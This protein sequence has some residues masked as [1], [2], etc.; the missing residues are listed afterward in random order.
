MELMDDCLK[1]VEAT[2]SQTWVT[3]L[4]Q[5]A[6]N[7]GY[8]RVLF[9]LKPGKD[10][11]NASATV[12]GNF[13]PAWRRRY[14]DMGFVN[15]DPTVSHSFASSLPLVWGSALYA[16]PAQAH[17][18]EEAAAANLS[19]GVT[20]PMHGP[21]GQVG[22]LS[23]SCEPVAQARYLAQVQATLGSAALL[24]DYAMIS[25]IRLFTNAQHP[26]P[27]LTAREREILTW[28]WSGKTTW[29]IGTI[30][31]ISEPAVEFHFKNVRQKLKVSSRRLAVARAMQLDLISP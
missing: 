8:S 18:A 15:L 27:R 24:R 23:L 6:A 12:T 19:H 26:T 7:L 3:T 22:M 11:P 2:D 21:Q 30:L 16:T 31:G 10:A 5:A 4:A 28:A 17:F 25:G 13:N 9:G 14:E 29:E 20:L 1:L